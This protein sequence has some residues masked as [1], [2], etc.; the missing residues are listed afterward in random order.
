M[1]ITSRPGQTWAAVPHFYCLNHT[2]TGPCGLV[3]DERTGGAS[4]TDSALGG[5]RSGGVEAEIVT[6]CRPGS[7]Q[8]SVLG[9]QTGPEIYCAPPLSAV[10]HTGGVMLKRVEGI[11]GR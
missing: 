5:C 7:V 2:E 11:S 3:Q 4:G 8:V 6:V 9:L 1:V 10:E